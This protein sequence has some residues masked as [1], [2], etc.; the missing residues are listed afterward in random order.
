MELTYQEV[1]PTNPTNARKR[2]VPTDQHT[3]NSCET[4]RRCKTSPQRVRQWVK[5]E[6]IRRTRTARPAQNP[7][8]PAQNN[9][10]QQ[11][12]ACCNATKKTTTDANTSPDT[13]PN[14]ASTS[15][16]TPSDTASDATHQQPTARANSAVASIP[17]TGR[18]RAKNRLRSFKPM[19]KTSPTRARS[20]PNAGITCAST[21]CLATS[22]L[23]LKVAR[24]CAC[25]RSAVRFPR[26]TGW[27]F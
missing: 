26:C 6:T 14:T 2:I 21:A 5:H 22:G 25:W 27:R 7:Q 24:A 16:P 17:R 8:T 12:S 13:S 10:P 4:A 19:S 9:R 11:T 15:P 1:Y 3:Q 20:A 18:G 23:L